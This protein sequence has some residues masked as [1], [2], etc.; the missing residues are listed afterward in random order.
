MV[1]RLSMALAVIFIAF[2]V[3]IAQADD[4]SSEDPLFWMGDNLVMQMAIMSLGQ[5]AVH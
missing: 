4:S 2:T 1:K 5:Q 3:T